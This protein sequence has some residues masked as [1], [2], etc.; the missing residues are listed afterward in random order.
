MKTSK[1]NACICQQQQQW[2]FA[3]ASKKWPSV[4][5]GLV[6]VDAEGSYFFQEIGNKTPF[7]LNKFGK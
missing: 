3:A 4:K 5:L 1:L 6:G 2:A 7:V